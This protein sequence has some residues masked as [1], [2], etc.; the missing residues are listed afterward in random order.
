MSSSPQANKD[1]QSL[2]I[3]NMERK[4][5]LT[6]FSVHN[7]KKDAYSKI[8]VS[9]YWD[10]LIYIDDDYLTEFEILKFKELYYQ[11]L[12]EISG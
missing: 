6:W 8:C 12:Q 9:Q 4:L 3:Y 10:W 2:M 7:R 11:Q 5:N 1:D